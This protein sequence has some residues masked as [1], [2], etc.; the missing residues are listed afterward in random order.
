MIVS[1]KDAKAQ[2]VLCILADTHYELL[3]NC[4]IEPYLNGREQGYSLYHNSK[5]IAWSECRNSDSFVV[6]YGNSHD[7][8]M[9][10]NVP[11]DEVYK[12]KKFF[13]PDEYCEVAQYIAKTLKG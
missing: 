4:L 1:R 13:C 12:N 9:G 8:D 7:F 2:A 3:K 6:Y 10:G 5:R 11:S